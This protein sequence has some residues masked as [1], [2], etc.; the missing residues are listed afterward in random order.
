MAQQK[1]PSL[2]TTTAKAIR[3]GF[4][5]YFLL[6]ITLCVALYFRTANINNQ[7]LIRWDE[8]MYLLQSITLESLT[9]YAKPLHTLLVH[10][11]IMLFG[12]ED[13]AGKAIS[14]FLGILTIASSYLLGAQ[15]QSRMAG[16]LSAFLLAFS[17]NHVYFSRLNHAQADSTFFI[18][19]AALAAAHTTN[20]QTRLQISL[21]SLASGAFSGFAFTC[22][23][24][25]AICTLS[26]GIYFTTRAL[27]N[28]HKKK[29]ASFLLPA[30][31]VLGFTIPVLSFEAAGRIFFDNQ[32]Y[33]LNALKHGRL[34]IEG[35]FGDYLFCIKQVIVWEGYSKLAIVISGLCYLNYKKI[36][37]R[38]VFALCIGI[39]PIF[40]Q[41]LTDFTADT[42][43][44]YTPMIIGINTLASIGIANHINTAL[45]NNSYKKPLA[46]LFYLIL[47]TLYARDNTTASMKFINSQGMWKK[48]AS[49]II[50]MSNGPTST[51]TACG[52]P[53]HFYLYKAKKLIIADS[54]A[55]INTAIHEFHSDTIISRNYSSSVYPG[56]S[57]YF[58][59]LNSQLTLMSIPTPPQRLQGGYLAYRADNL[60]L[61]AQA[62]TNQYKTMTRSIE[63]AFL[64]WRET[65]TSLP[66]AICI[67]TEAT[68]NQ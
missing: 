57:E 1:H 63:P 30:L 12:L 44:H 39:I 25:T 66:G 55:D 41:S 56:T 51:C 22:H 49:A 19:L 17:Y 10:F 11:G 23:P 45:H 14:I 48:T 6:L 9:K 7:G 15:L 43:R 42:D 27:Y 50:E 46:L 34:A 58:R 29:L 52:P 20:T 62:T 40:L 65:L 53:I 67:N 18:S 47:L 38:T 36:D 31:Q 21:L 60:K 32:S 26:I 8:G 13:Y 28:P 33:I 3:P 37:T 54:L 4:F 61:D 5:V 59:V 24:N 16:L 2:R 64:E 35:S 68:G